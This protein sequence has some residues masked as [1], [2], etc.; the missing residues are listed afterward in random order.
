MFG[1]ICFVANPCIRY[2]M[3]VGVN[4]EVKR[5]ENLAFLKIL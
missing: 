2:K 3:V 4:E 1:P 5:K